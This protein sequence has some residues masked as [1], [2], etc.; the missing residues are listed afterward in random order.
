MVDEGPIINSIHNGPLRV[1]GAPLKDHEGNPIETRKVYILCRCGRSTD[2][3]FCDGSHV[4]AE[5]KDEKDPERVPNRMDN[6]VG[7]V[8]EIHDNRGVCSHRGY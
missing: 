6:Y 2:K 1:D 5:W 8:L 3:P 7:K 4:K